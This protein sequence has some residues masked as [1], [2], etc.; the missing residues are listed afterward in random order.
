MYVSLVCSELKKEREMLT[1]S[2][3]HVD[4]SS[5]EIISLSL[6]RV[7]SSEPPIEMVS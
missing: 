7:T 3:T 6:K 2:F 5:F 4:A 1:L